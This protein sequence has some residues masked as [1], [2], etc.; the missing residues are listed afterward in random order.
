VYT[1][2]QLP[3]G[4]YKVEPFFRDAV[5]SPAVYEDLIIP[6]NDEVYY[7]FT[8]DCGGVDT[9]GDGLGDWCEYNEPPVFFWQTQ[10]GEGNPPQWAL[11]EENII[12]DNDTQVILWT[13]EDPDAPDDGLGWSSRKGIEHSYVTYRAVGQQDW[14]AETETVWSRR[15]VGFI[16]MWS[17]VYPA[18][19][20]PENGNYEIKLISEDVYGARC[21]EV[22]LIS[23]AVP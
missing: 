19:F 20:I 9:D 13:T 5:F 22:W 21:E 10:F 11:M 8:A 15:P 6:R 18:S 3:G 7:D 14:Q 12:F 2:D 16:G 1:F 23:I 17:W 4:V